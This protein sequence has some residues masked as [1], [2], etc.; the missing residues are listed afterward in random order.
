[1]NRLPLAVLTAIA[2]LLFP[3]VPAGAGVANLGLAAALRS[4]PVVGLDWGLYQLDTFDPGQDPPSAYFNLA[5][6]DA[7]RAAFGKI[8]AQPRF[9]WFGDW[10]PTYDE[11]DVW[12]ARSAAQNYIEQ[13]T[14]GDPDVAAGMAVFRLSPFEAAGCRRLPSAQERADYRDWIREFAAGIGGTRAVLALQPDLPLALCAPHHS[15]INMQLVSWSTR[16][17]GAL[18]HTTVYLD[19][20]AADWLRPGQAASLLQRSG[21]RWA[22]GFMLDLTH[23]DSTARQVAYGHRILRA[24]A[25]RGIRGKHFVVNTAQNGRP[26]DTH[27]YWGTFK[28]GTVCTT[29]GSRHCVTLGH[30]PTTR[31]GD[32]AVDA[33]LW[34]G[35]PW[36]NNEF[37]RSYEETLRLV[38]TSPFF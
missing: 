21:V 20:G 35:R 7:D 31:T 4:N 23:Y 32:A 12:G 14:G 38:R 18:P 3:A 1:V 17:F 26:F 25:G 10:Y 22:R 2:L 11:G 15:P 37:R 24:L 6:T 36:I 33:Y 5:N 8:L 28:R 30:P 19:A 9:R 13:V 16:V 29:R 27:H 34:I